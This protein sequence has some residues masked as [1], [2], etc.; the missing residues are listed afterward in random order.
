MD[1]TLGAA[2][3]S[4]IALLNSVVLCTDD[5]GVNPVLLD[6]SVF[7]STEGGALVVDSFP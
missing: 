2:V 3:V 6:D 4:S 1:T 7:D 5:V